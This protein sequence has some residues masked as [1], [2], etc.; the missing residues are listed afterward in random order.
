MSAHLSFSLGRRRFSVALSAAEPLLA[1]AMKLRYAIG[2]GR[3]AAARDRLPICWL[4]IYWLS[5]PASHTSAGAGYPKGS[6]TVNFI[7][8]YFN[9]ASRLMGSGF[10]SPQSA[11][12]KA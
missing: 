6:A 9:S 7:F 11:G 10:V 2:H 12:K 3:A 8:I 5:G 1:T 4:P